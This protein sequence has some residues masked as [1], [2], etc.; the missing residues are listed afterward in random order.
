MKRRKFLNLLVSLPIVEQ[1]KAR[2]IRLKKASPEHGNI[3]RLRH[4]PI[5]YSEDPGTQLVIDEGRFNLPVLIKDALRE[6]NCY[7]EYVFH[8][9]GSPYTY[10][11]IRCMENFE[12]VY[13]YANTT[14]TQILRANGLHVLDSGHS[15]NL[16]RKFLKLTPPLL[17]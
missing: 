4:R 12:D 9:D 15:T 8:I 14:H 3:V 17:P 5:L 16:K 7:V 13:S 6:Y 1:C 11:C 2:D 10:I